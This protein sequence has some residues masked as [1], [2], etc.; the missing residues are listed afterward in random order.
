M[1]NTT[2][3]ILRVNFERLITIIDSKIQFERKLFKNNDTIT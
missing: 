2:Y 3:M 1:M